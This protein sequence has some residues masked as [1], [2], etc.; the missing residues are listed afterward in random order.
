MFKIFNRELISIALAIFSMFFGA[1]NVIFPLILGMEA[2]SQWPFAFGGLLLTAI[3]G[4][5]LGL[6]GA[7]FYKGRFIDFFRWTGRVPSF[8]LITTTLA[9]LGPF[10]VLP[11]CVTVAH[12]ATISLIPSCNL[13]VFAWVFCILAGLLCWKRRY[14]L[15]ILGSVLSPL[16]I[17]CLL[18]IITESFLNEDIILQGSLSNWDAFVFGL[19]TGY[20]TM[21]LIAAIYFA[22]GLWTMIML[23]TRRVEG[24]SDNSAILRKTL[25]A[26]LL[27][28]LLLAIIYLGLAQAAASYAPLI[29]ETPKE[30]LMTRLAILA[31]GPSLGSVANIAVVLACLTTVVSLTMTIG[32]ILYDELFNGKVSYH[33]TLGTILLITAVM[34]NLGFDAI[35]SI[36]HPVVSVCY[37]FI[38][39]L[40]LVNIYKKIFMTD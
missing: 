4:P 23:N 12:A 11:R 1:G 6:V 40:T 8:I 38:I 25:L 13:N 2:Q 22:S 30:Q 14:I 17:G 9:L 21:D 18:L 31:L 7:T 35:M 5:L 28:C 34:S 26:G 19:S 16:L 33:T 15:P 20:D 29:K 27:G 32:N 24:G 37:P 36:I 3:G 10:A 39:L